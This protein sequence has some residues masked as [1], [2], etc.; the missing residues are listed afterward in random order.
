MPGLKFNSPPQRRGGAARRGGTPS[1]KNDGKSARIASLFLFSPAFLLA[2]VPQSAG[3]PSTA[4]TAEGGSTSCFSSLPMG[5]L[6]LRLD[7]AR[8]Q[9]KLDRR[10]IWYK[11]LRRK[12]ET[13]LASLSSISEARSLLLPLFACLQLI[14]KKAARSLASLPSSLLFFPPP[15]RMVMANLHLTA[16]RPQ[17]AN[18][19]TH[20]TQRSDSADRPTAA[21]ADS[22]IL[23]NHLRR[24]GR[25]HAAKQCPLRE[26]AESLNHWWRL[27][28]S[29]PVSSFGGNGSRVELAR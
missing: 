26:E 5:S 29:N 2:A 27:S 16:L 22:I 7:R 9:V 8:G 23:A 15:S 4:G 17:Y 11:G 25:P 24:A 18:W 28:S 12:E 20:C 14:L 3:Q 6:S 10:P 1:E 19:F 21:Q 13:R